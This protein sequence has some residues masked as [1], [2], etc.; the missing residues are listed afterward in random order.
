VRTLRLHAPRHLTMPEL[1]V[2][3][4]PAAAAA[5]ETKKEPVEVDLIDLLGGWHWQMML[6]TFFPHV[7]DPPFSTYTA[8]HDVAST[9]PSAGNLALVPV[10]TFERC[11]P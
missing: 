4:A 10:V 8:S 1:K 11:F 6:A 3:A 7:L 2:E 9:S 5:P